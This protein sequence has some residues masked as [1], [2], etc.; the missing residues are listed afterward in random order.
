MNNE[1]EK[2]IEKFKEVKNL[3]KA[4]SARDEAIKFLANETKL[5][6]QECSDAYDII[7]KIEDYNLKTML[8][9]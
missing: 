5:S 6:I 4:F 2:A 3:L 7:M 9:L 1:V 8:F